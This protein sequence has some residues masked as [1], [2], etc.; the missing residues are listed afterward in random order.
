MRGRTTRVPRPRRLAIEAL[1]DRAVPA[2]FGVPWSDPSHLSLS[3]APDGTAIAGHTSSL[4][5]TM[6][7]SKA[8][9][10]WQVDIL[11][12]FQTWAVNANINIGLTAD[13]GQAFGI[14]GASQ[15]D[16]RFGDIRVGAQLMA[17][18]ALSISVPNDPAISS[19]MTGDVLINNADNFSKYDLFA[20]ALHE[21]GHV[22][23]IGD[24]SNPSSPMNSHYLGNVKLTVGD[25]ADL[26]ALYGARGP[27]S[28]EGSGGNDT[29]ARA[30]T[31]QPPGGWTGATPLVTY[32]DITTN[33]D[34]DFLAFRPPS[35]YRGPLTVRLQSA[36]IS[37]LAPHV[38]IL[39][40]KGRVLGD[41]QAQS[42]MGTWSPF[43]STRP[44]RTRRTTSRFRGR[45][46]DRKSVV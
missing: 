40:A 9:S 3:F 34:I 25:I 7:A 29:L 19:T 27:D 16:S 13:G 12:A 21:A 28:H 45:R 23:G 39:D 41:A 35:G 36:G 11:R 44:T 38:S 31:I 42:D 24:N 2:T 46:E 22:F 10:T 20:V 26:Q 14:S 15:H 5:Q 8:A 30:S 33:K 37:L 4:F 17:S 18:D 32:G 1:E 6:A 43:I